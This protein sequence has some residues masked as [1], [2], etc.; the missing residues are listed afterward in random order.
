MSNQKIRKLKDEVNAEMLRLYKLH[1]GLRPSEVVEA[2]AQKNSPL[3]GEYE[4]DN[5]KAGH[6]YRL[7]QARKAIRLVVIAIEPNKPERFVHIPASADVEENES[8]EGV[9]QPISLVI[10]HP[11][12]FAKALGEAQSKLSSAKAAMAE[13]QASAETSDRADARVP[14]ILA[15]LAALEIADAAVRRLH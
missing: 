10:E 7:I 6:E 13:L 11:D 4:W 14:V 8:S 3:H 15:A 5:K 2:A 12:W 9:Y 1:D